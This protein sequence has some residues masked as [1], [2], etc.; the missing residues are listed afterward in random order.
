MAHAEEMRQYGTCKGKI[1]NREGGTKENDT[2]ENG[3]IRNTVLL[4]DDNLDVLKTLGT[5]LAR[6][7]H[8]VIAKLDA[9]SAMEILR[10][11]IPVDV[12][13]TDYQLPQMDGMEFLGRLR[14]TAPAVPVIVLTGYGSVENYLQFITRGAYEY[15]HKPVLPRELNRV[16]LAALA[17]R[18][19]RKNPGETEAVPPSGAEQ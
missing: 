14:E 8:R 7:G 18:E 12:I 1:M 15:L 6:A 16:V 5:V 19:K 4:V 17:N 2:K 10:E 11:G 9:P 3:T 13:V